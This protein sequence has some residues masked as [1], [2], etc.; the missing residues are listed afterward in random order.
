MSWCGENEHSRCKFLGGSKCKKSIKPSKSPGSAT[1][2]FI[3]SLVTEICSKVANFPFKMFMVQ[4]GL[5]FT[6]S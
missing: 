4:M 6:L 5:A 1:A 3:T 2:W